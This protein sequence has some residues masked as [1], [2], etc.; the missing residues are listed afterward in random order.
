MKGLLKMTKVELKKIVKKETILVFRNASTK[1]N[2]LFLTILV[3][4]IFKNFKYYQ[5]K[6]MK[7]YR[8]FNYY[9]KHKRKYF[10]KLYSGRKYGKYSLKISCQINCD[11]IGEGLVFNHG[12]IVINK[13]CVIGKN[14][15]LV[16]GNCI[17]GTNNGAPKIG[18]NVF[19]GYGTII[20]GNINIGNDCKIGGGAIVTK[21]V[22]PRA[23]VVG[24][25]KVIKY[26]S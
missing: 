6:L 2:S 24:I 13:S 7:S 16:G 12:D 8:Y 5:Y 17:G 20:L 18:D 4:R 26:D 15:N 25:N 11:N 1:F 23:T 10:Q 19:I 22:P 9:Q 3:H 21:D 14:V